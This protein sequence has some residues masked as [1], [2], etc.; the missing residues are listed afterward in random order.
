MIVVSRHFQAGESAGVLV[1]DD[2]KTWEEAMNHLRHAR[3]ELEAFAREFPEMLAV[4][5]PWDPPA[6][7]EPPGVVAR[8][9]EAGRAVNVGPMAAVA[10]AL[11]DEVHDRLHPDPSVTFVMENGGE[12]LVHAPRPV[13]VALHAGTA[14]IG[15]RLGFVI[16]PDDPAVHG[17]GTSSARLGHAMSFGHADTVTVFCASA[18]LADAAATA[19]CNA[20]IA[21]DDVRS[22]ERAIEAASRVP[23]ITGIFVVQGGHVGKAGRVPPVVEIE[24]AADVATS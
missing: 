19:T 16:P 14:A 9:I 22:I 7:A 8:M 6:R 21:G 13:T 15:S 12:I 5:E 3:A 1:C 20:T 17:I 10:G 2:E 11:V 23:S 24:G 18:A 4:L